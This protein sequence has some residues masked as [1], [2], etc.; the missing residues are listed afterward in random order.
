MAGAGKHKM[1]FSGSGACSVQL[2]HG[3]V[4]ARDEERGVRRRKAGPAKARRGV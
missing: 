4:W 3:S 2:E 1:A